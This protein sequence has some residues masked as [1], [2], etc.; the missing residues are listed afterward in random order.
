[1]IQLPTLLHELLRYRR[2]SGGDGNTMAKD[3]IKEVIRDAGYTCFEDA[4]GNII[5]TTRF[6]GVLFSSHTDTVHR[7]EGE[8]DIHVD[9]FGIVTAWHRK[10]INGSPKRLRDVLGADDAAGIYLM[11]S[12][13][14]FDIPGTY[15]FHADEEIGCIGSRALASRPWSIDG[16]DLDEDFTHAIAFDRMGTADLI[17]HQ[18]G[19]RM[20]SED[21]ASELATRFRNINA[22][23]RYKP[24]EGVVTDT[25]MYADQVPECIN[26]SVGYY[27]EHTSDERLDLTHLMDLFDVVTTHGVFDDLPVVRDP[28][29][30]EDSEDAIQQQRE[31]YTIVRPDTVEWIVY[32]YPEEVASLLE[33]TFGYD[34]HELIGALEEASGGNL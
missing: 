6:N 29:A 26:L 32:T 19:E 18:M 16:Y 22:H 15:V 31:D 1:M 17:T 34:Y 28:T 13:I 8:L 9:D 7:D 14:Q 12:M 25:A 27:N 11:L 4:D 5:S 3:L 20:C 30:Y 24:A 10:L 21:C 2:P 33:H 23:L